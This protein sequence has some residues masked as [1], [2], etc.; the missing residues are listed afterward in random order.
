L[1][2]NNLTLNNLGLGARHI[3]LPPVTLGEHMNRDVLTVLGYKP[4][5]LLPCH[6]KLIS[7]CWGSITPKLP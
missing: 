3:P 2:L 7:S 6:V 5:K 1:T 4:P